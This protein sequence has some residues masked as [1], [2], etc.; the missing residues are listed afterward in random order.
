MQ[1]IYLIETN[2][3]ILDSLKTQ[4]EAQGYVIECNSDLATGLKHIIQNPP[5]LVLLPWLSAPSSIYEVSR[6]LKKQTQFKHIPLL[7]LVS[8]EKLAETTELFKQ[9]FD[10]YLCS[11]P[12]TDE[13]EIK[14]KRQLQLNKIAEKMPNLLEKSD[15]SN[16]VCANA[17][18]L[19]EM[20]SK[21]LNNSFE[22]EQRLDAHTQ[23][24]QELNA[25]YE[26]FV[27]H[28]FLIFLGKDSI[29][30][31]SLGDQVQ[32][33]MT[34]L[35]LDI[36]DFTSLSESMTPQQNFN[37]LNE[38]L[39]QISPIIK[40]HHGFIDKYIGDA[41]MAL[42]PKHHAEDA[43]QAAISIHKTISRHNT[44]LKARNLPKV[45]IGIGIHTGILMLGI[46]GERARLQ[47]TVISDSVN[48]AAR[49]ESLTKHYGANII[50]SKQT[51]HHI[52]D[53]GHYHHR[54]VGKIRVKGKSKEVSVYEVFEGDNK[55][56]LKLKL[57]NKRTFEQGLSYYQQGKF[58]EASVQFHQVLERHDSDKAA[59]LYLN[60]CAQ[61]M[62]GKIPDNW[63]GV[64]NLLHK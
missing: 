6:Y 47:S 29:T 24:L 5:D 17:E 15:L 60:Y 31:V 28:E 34:I 16:Y 45:R 43:L 53:K 14:I 26:R 64:E 19:Q 48:L 22:L 42:F 11:P 61:L 41:V 21:L 40:R 7:L 39:S 46:I 36:R 44:D 13:I 3:S 2:P 20:V 8:I 50:I 23:E 30:E 56:T 25:V 63:D 12:Q 37:F 55:N 57:K 18:K 4:L 49:L 1:R 54:F 32:Q 52:H 9:G 33:E 38:C 58:A 35:F 59:R 62:V 27:P 51:L 10:D